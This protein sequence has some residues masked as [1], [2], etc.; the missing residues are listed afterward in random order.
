M[1]ALLARRHF[2]AITGSKFRIQSYPL[3]VGKLETSWRS[4]FCCL[5]CLNKNII[6]QIFL[7][8]VFG[9]FFRSFSSFS[10][11][12]SIGLF[13]MGLFCA[14]T[15]KMIDW[16]FV[17]KYTNLNF[18]KNILWDWKELNN[19]FFLKTQ[20]FFLQLRFSILVD[21]L[22]NKIKCSWLLC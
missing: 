2:A 1:G 10:K 13:C 17:A 15:L 21:L 18:I 12:Y 7:W 19:F 20:V 11:L 16:S 3:S 5:C 4:L 8:I 6:K 9:L 14:D 22:P